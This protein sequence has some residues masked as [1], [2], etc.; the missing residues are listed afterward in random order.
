MIDETKRNVRKSKKRLTGRRV[1]TSKSSQNTKEAFSNIKHRTFT[2]LRK[3]I[4]KTVRKI[5]LKI[6][7]KKVIFGGILPSFA[8]ALS[9]FFRRIFTVLLSGNLRVK[10]QATDKAMR[11]GGSAGGGAEVES[12]ADLQTA[13]RSNVANCGRSL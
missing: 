6:A 10:M 12:G 1:R 2:K 9:S 11:A 3:S 4:L 5:K 13:A 7:R 8:V